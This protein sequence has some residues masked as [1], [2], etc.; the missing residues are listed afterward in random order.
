LDNVGNFS[1]CVFTGLSSC[2]PQLNWDPST[3][4]KILVFAEAQQGGN[5]IRQFFRQAELARL[6]KDCQAGL[7]H[8][9]DAFMV[10]IL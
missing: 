6:L 5:K 10:R 9:V 1:K 3:L 4:Q 7:Q 2:Q 8:A